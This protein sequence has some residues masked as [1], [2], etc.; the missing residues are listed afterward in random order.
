MGYILT[1]NSHCGIHRKYIDEVGICV[2]TNLD[3]Q[4]ITNCV[5]R[6]LDV[7][8]LPE[9][10]TCEKIKCYLVAVKLLKIFRRNI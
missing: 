7:H 9:I 3:L 6:P 8:R 4:Q 1:I 5:H 2:S 10:G